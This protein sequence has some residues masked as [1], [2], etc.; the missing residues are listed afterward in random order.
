MEPN[1]VF[2]QAR[3]ACQ[4]P[5]T[6]VSELIAS[7]ADSVLTFGLWLANIATYLNPRIDDAPAPSA[8]SKMDR[9]TRK[10]LAGIHCGQPTRD[11]THKSPDRFLKMIKNKKT[12]PKGHKWPKKS[13]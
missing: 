6:K 10:M 3:E 9:S 1:D 5:L 8:P 2:S 12:F 13:I 11:R 4:W 7:L